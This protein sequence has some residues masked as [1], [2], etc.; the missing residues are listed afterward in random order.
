M[1]VRVGVDLFVDR[2]DG[3]PDGIADLMQRLNVPGARLTVIS[4]RGTKVWPDGNPDTYWS[5][6][7]QCRFEGE[8]D[9]VFSQDHVIA[10]MHAASKAGFDVIKTEGLYTFNGERGFSLAQGQ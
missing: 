3:T 6:H 4:N 2:R 9:G 7:W 8:G 10:L 5:D 1:K